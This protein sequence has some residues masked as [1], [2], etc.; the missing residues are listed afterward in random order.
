MQAVPLGSR[1]SNPSPLWEKR[2]RLGILAGQGRSEQGRGW[3]RPVNK[4]WGVDC[5][6]SP[7]CRTPGELMVSRLAFQALCLRELRPHN[8][9]SRH[10]PHP[11]VNEGLQL[12]DGGWSQGSQISNIYITVQ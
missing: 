3:V 6:L 1:Q 10:G 4:L 5:L 12:H 2:V 8:D 9:V 7:S 11:V